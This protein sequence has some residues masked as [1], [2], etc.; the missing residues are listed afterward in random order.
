MLRV[1]RAKA[2]IAAFLLFASSATTSGAEYPDHG[3][4]LTVARPAG[5]DPIWSAALSQ[6]GSQWRSNSRL[7]L[8]I[9]Q[10]QIAISQ[11]TCSRSYWPTA[12]L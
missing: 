8:T 3:V 7:W 11:R 6:S 9:G 5:V 12:T 2:I 4:K 10:A 1:D